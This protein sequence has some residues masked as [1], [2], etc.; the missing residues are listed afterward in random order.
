MKSD[1]TDVLIVGCGPAG[2]STA[3]HLCQLDP[4][5]AGR[6]LMLDRAHHSREK[7]CGGILSFLALDVLRRLDLSVGVPSVA[8]DNA[9]IR[10]LDTRILFSGPS[11]FRVI[12]RS[13]F[14]AWL[15]RECENRGVEVSQ[16]ESLLDLKVGDREV[17]ATTSKRTIRARTV[18]AADG[19]TGVTRRLLFPGD[20]TRLCRLL[21]IL[22]PADPEQEWEFRHR[23]VYSDWSPMVRGIQGYYWDVPSLV[24]G[25]PMMNRGLFDSRTYQRRGRASGSMKEVFESFLPVRGIDLR[26]CR[27]GGFPIR[28]L[29]G[30]APLS[31][32]RVLFVGD[33]AGADPLAGEGISFALGYGRPAAAAIA[34]ATSRG[35]FSYGGY[36]DC[37]RDDPIFRHLLVRVK[38]ARLTYLSSHPRFLQCSL[39]L[40]GNCFARTIDH[41][42][43]QC[44]TP[45]VRILPGLPGESKEELEPFLHSIRRKGAYP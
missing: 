15:L 2:S 18:V 36:R 19:T 38:L 16:G 20:R 3:L 32:E 21:E 24:A 45:E 25:V 7:L 33:A 39:R 22:T 14:D 35:D 10:C 34:D 13:E 8:I 27:L 12:R 17:L 11:V 5:W 9:I 37:L 26:D 40:V 43:R 29:D 4:G 30:R 44:P 42:S 1:S 6:I 23:A 31:A 41:F 28:P